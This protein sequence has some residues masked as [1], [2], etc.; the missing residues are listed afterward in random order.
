MDEKKNS[1]HCIAISDGGDN[2]HTMRDEC[3]WNVEENTN[4]WRTQRV[5][6]CKT[7]EKIAIGVC[8]RQLSA[9]LWNYNL[10]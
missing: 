4:L 8:L 6:F 3:N 1:F 10:I 9:P 7:M 5:P 2:T